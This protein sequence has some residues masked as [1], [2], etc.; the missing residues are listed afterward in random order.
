[1]DRGREV[2]T[3]GGR[4]RRREG[5]TEGEGER[6]RDRGESGREGGIEEGGRGREREPGE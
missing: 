3:K 2:E 6:R 1:M 5:E 4:E